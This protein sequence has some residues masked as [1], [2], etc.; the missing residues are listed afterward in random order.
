EQHILPR[1]SRYWLQDMKEKAAIRQI[2]IGVNGDDQI[3]FETTS[4]EGICHKS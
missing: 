4:Q 3:V 2:D 1:L